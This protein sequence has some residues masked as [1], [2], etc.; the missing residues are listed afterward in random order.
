MANNKISITKTPTIILNTLPAIFPQGKGYAFRY[1]LEKPIGEN[2]D[3]CIISTYI[4]IDKDPEISLNELSTTTTYN[5]KTH[6][7]ITEIYQI[8]YR[9]IQ[10]EI[11]LFNTLYQQQ[12]LVNYP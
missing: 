12:T 2:M 10:D 9:C 8:F 11:A 3:L 6:H 4:I 5:I 7:L 1:D